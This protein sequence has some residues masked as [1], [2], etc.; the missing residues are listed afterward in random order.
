M[1]ARTG[2]PSGWSSPCRHFIAAHV[3]RRRQRQALARLARLSPRL[4]RDAG[5]DPAVVHDAVAG[6][7]DEV[8]PGRY[9]DR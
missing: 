6:T 9:H 4:I 8:A 5:F 1:P 3:R 7:W 2:R